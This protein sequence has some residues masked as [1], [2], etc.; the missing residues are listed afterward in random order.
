MEP[1]ARSWS[2]GVDPPPWKR[3]IGF[4]LLAVKSIPRPVT[5]AW[6]GFAPAKK[7]PPVQF[8]PG[9]AWSAVDL[10]KMP[11]VW[12]AAGIASAMTPAETTPRSALIA[13]RFTHAI[14]LATIRPKALTSVVRSTDAAAEADEY[15]ES[16]DPSDDPRPLALNWNVEAVVPNGKLPF[17]AKNW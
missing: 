2:S 4:V 16:C 5:L 15:A 12:L 13:A 1:S 10:M 14:W 17:A 9:D 7:M 11:F 6:I 3:R 8:A